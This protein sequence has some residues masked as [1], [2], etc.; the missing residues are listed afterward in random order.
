MEIFYGS[1]G[2]FVQEEKE[3]LV[4]KLKKVLYVLKQSLR[5]WYHRI[6]SFFIN[7]GFCR[8]QADHLLYTKQASEYLLVAIL[9]VDN[10][11]IL[12][13]NVTQLKWLKLELNKK[14]EISGLGVLYYCLVV[15][16]ERNR[17]AH[18]II[19]NQSSYIEEVLKRST[20]KNTN[21]SELHLMQ[22]QN[23]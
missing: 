23:Y 22:I 17:E 21:W 4:C 12:A 19:M 20:W 2:E 6:D 7:E 15:E 18:T 3:H 16:F 13:S 5:V 8:S 1:T 9:Y 14:F 11:I 10:V